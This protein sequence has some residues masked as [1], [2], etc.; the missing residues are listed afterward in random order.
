[1]KDALR[2]G[3]SVSTPEHRVEVR[4]NERPFSR[5]SLFHLQIS[6]IASPLYGL[7]V[8]CAQSQIGLALLDEALQRIQ[9]TI[10]EHRG[11]FEKKME[12]RV[13]S[14]DDVEKLL[15]RKRTNSF[16]SIWKEMFLFRH[17]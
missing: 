13:I 11:Y 17:V 10:A 8:T 14:D 7:N 5:T 9:T 2:A 16:R 3:L 4:R 1:M 12:P 6:L 15:V